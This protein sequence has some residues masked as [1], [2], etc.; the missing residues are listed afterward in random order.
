MDYKKL[1]EQTYLGSGFSAQ[2]IATKQ[3]LPVLA[4][5]PQ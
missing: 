4:I 1:L 3:V 2:F 5:S